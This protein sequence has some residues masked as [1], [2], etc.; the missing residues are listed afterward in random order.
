MVDVGKEYFYGPNFLE[1]LRLPPRSDLSAFVRNRKIRGDRILVK[2]II[3]QK[4]AAYLRFFQNPL[5]RHQN[6]KEGILLFIPTASCLRV[7]EK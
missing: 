2:V 1:Y 4:I 5:A 6:L 3:S 7:A